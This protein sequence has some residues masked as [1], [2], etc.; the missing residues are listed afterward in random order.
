[1]RIGILLCD[2]V[3][4]DLQ[5]VHGTY[6]RMFE[7]FLP[8]TNFQPYFVCDDDFPTSVSDC[9]GYL[10]NGS[11]Y[12][13]YDEISWIQR[14]K[15]FV[16]DI[17]H[18]GLPYVGVCFGHQILAEALGGTVLKSPQGWCVGKHNFKV[19]DDISWMDP[20]LQQIGL[21]MM[22][23]DQVVDLPPGSSVMASNPACPIA[24]FTVGEHMFGIQAHPEF[25]PSY[26]AAI[27]DKRREKIGYDKVAE[28]RRSL[29]LPLDVDPIRKWIGNFFFR[30][31]ASQ[32]GR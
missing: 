20:K 9:D 4:D 29:H 10:V 25:S 24:M 18:T 8:E 28:A 7:Q 23:Q 14:L 31:R 30:Q 12:S 15:D 27:L 13:V 11:R 32:L 5:A 22:C 3:D 2:H 17:H 26:L 16:Q 19:D 6:L 1:M 21:L